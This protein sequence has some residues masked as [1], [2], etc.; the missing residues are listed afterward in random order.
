MNVRVCVFVSVCACAL[1]Y[2]CAHRLSRPDTA[3]VPYDEAGLP[4]DGPHKRGEGLAHDVIL[5]QRQHLQCV[6]VCLLR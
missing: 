6:R 1:M 3:K 5:L 2:A 4:G